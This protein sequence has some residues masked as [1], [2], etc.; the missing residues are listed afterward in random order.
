[1]SFRWPH[2]MP[3]DALSFFNEIPKY[4]PSLKRVGL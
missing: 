3:L 4:V 2:S 1:L